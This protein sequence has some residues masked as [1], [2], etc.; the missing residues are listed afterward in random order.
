IATIRSCYRQPLVRK[1][2]TGRDSTMSQTTNLNEVDFEAVA[3]LVGA[4]DAEPDKGQTVWQA[5][6]HW[7]GGF[8]SEAAVRE[9]TIESDEP[10]SLGGTDS[11]PN[12]V[13]QV[14]AALGN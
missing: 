9:F 12:P 13:E 14:A 1:A 3:S 2:A 6:V 4:V 8:R 11:A 5:D 10:A 7:A